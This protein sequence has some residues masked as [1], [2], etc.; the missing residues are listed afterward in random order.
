MQENLTITAFNNEQQQLDARA[1]RVRDLFTQSNWCGLVAH[2]ES[3][4]S[5]LSEMRSSPPVLETPVCRLIPPVDDRYIALP[6]VMDSIEECFSEAIKGTQQGRFAIYGMGGAGKSSLAAYYAKN[7]V[8]PKRH[9]FWIGGKTEDTLNTSFGEIA[10]ALKLETLDTAAI[11]SGRRRDAVKNHLSHFAGIEIIKFFSIFADSRAIAQDW[12]LVF[13]DVEDFKL[14]ADYWP[15]CDHGSIIVTS[16][17]P[18]SKRFCEGRGVE[19]HQ[20][21]EDDAIQLLRSYLPSNLR[22]EDQDLLRSFSCHTLGALPLAIKLAAFYILEHHC[23]LKTYID[24]MQQGRDVVERMHRFKPSGDSAFYEHTIATCWNI[25]KEKMKHEKKS[26][27]LVLLDLMMFMDNQGLPEE[28]FSLLGN[29]PDTLPELKSLTQPLNLVEAV[30]ILLNYSLLQMDDDHKTFTIHPMIHAAIYERM[31][32]SERESAHKNATYILW[33]VFPGPL[34]GNDDMAAR[35]KVSNVYFPHLLCNWTRGQ[36]SGLPCSYT[37]AM[38]LR[39][40]AQ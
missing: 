31:S 11:S 34:Q 3:V 4:D 36:E 30:A 10:L 13:D 20:M 32:Q 12:L 23:S 26:H 24:L 35:W 38:T 2:Y 33:K 15:K 18:M 16:R 39:N 6:T 40:G 21:A 14:L 29:I 17:N 9:V 37:G 27:A 25:S 28:T 7:R 22:G 19:L 8:D 5:R 1:N